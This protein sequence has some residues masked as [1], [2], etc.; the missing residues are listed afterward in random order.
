[1]ATGLTLVLVSV[2]CLALA[3][4]TIGVPG[5]AA[6]TTAVPLSHLPATAFGPAGRVITAVAAVWGAWAG[7]AFTA[8]RAGL[9]R[10]AAPPGRPGR[11]RA[12]HLPAAS[13]G[14]R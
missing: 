14:R 12:A 7:L 2:L 9:L 11:G 4:T 5:S 1:M 10:P 8:P 6:G 3:V 13:P